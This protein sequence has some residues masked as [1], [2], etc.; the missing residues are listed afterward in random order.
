MNVRSR[1][2]LWHAEDRA[3]FV[4][5][6]SVFVAQDNRGALIGPKRVERGLER[7]PELLA[8]DRIGWLVRRVTRRRYGL[9]GNLRRARTPHRVD[10]GVVRDSEEPARQP[11]RRVECGEAAKGLD[12][13]LL[14]EVLGE[15]PIPGHAVDEA[16]DRPLVAAHDLLESRLRAGKGLG[17]D[18]GLA[19]R[20]QID[21]DGLV[22]N[23]VTCVR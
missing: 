13:R 10:G 21:R 23:L 6:Q 1:G 7:M 14:R 3:D 8:F 18:P 5:G 20:F 19:Y 11:S 15:G 17:D 2:D 12:E 22:L 9:D 16:D 4:E